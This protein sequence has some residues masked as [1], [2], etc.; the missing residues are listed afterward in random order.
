MEDNTDAAEFGKLMREFFHKACGPNQVAAAESKLF[1]E[2][3]WAS[4]LAM[5]LPLVGIDEAAGGAGGSLADLMA[6][7]RA[8][9]AAA[10]PAPIAETQLA[11]WALATV[12]APLPKNGEPLT[13]LLPDARNS[14]ALES[15]KLT[16]SF[17]GVPWGRTATQAVGVLPDGDGFVLITLSVADAS[18]EPGLDLAGAPNDVLH[19]NHAA[20]DVVP[21]EQG[22]QE[23]ERRFALSRV[24]LMAGAL[25][26]VAALT[27]EYVKTR[28]QF[29][30][31]IGKFQSV[32]QHIV[33]LEQMST[34]SALA[35]DRAAQAF[36]AGKSFEALLAK[37]L[38]NDNARIAVRAAHQAHG[39]MGMTREYRLQLLTR[40]LNCWLGEG[41][42]SRDLVLRIADE[43]QSESLADIVSSH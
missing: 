36:A 24:A 20:V 41:G 42:S 15:G 39:A 8:Q 12:G 37:Q 34:M 2:Q 7:L 21:W 10:V 11:N 29:G 13:V 9:G 4:I 28:E 19:V 6:G 38:V 17:F 22:A 35:A 30:K 40:R 43:V 5:G 27:R 33:H 14:A 31:P 16:G 23:L 32:Q 18:I 1:D 25:E 26:E 3:L